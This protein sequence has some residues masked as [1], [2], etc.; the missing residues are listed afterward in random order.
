MLGGTI[1]NITGPCFKPEDK[2]TCLFDTEFVMGAVVDVNKAICVQPRL[3]YNG[4]IKLA[5]AINNGLLKWKGN[6]FVGKL[7]LT[8]TRDIR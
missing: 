6:F 7:I 3:Y 2:I 1:V 5:V 8:D 4:Y